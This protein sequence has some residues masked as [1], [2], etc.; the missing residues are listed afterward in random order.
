MQQQIRD[1]ISARLNTVPNIGTV[2][3]YQ[4]Y[5]DRE[6]QLADL[7]QYNG[8]LHGWFVRRTAVVER[9]LSAG[10]NTEQSTWLI[11]GY[12]AINDVVSSEV[13][14]DALLDGIRGVFR[15]DGFKPWLEMTNG[16][17][18]SLVYTEQLLKEQIGFAVLDS[19]PVL[20]SG[21]LCHS[22]QCQLIITR[23]LNV[24]RYAI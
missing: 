19:Q 12:L 13:E 8:R 7:Y 23:C 21:V 17:Q 4:R 9:T 1:F 16:E 11:R 20:F 5:A 14:F 2:H 22:A 6:K 18:I 24:N 15:T 10:I 3:S